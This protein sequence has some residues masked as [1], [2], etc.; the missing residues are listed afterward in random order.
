MAEKKRNIQK[1]GEK[2]AREKPL[3]GNPPDNDKIEN[4]GVLPA[5]DFKKNMGCG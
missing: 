4:S 1:R 2:K 5:V 3:K